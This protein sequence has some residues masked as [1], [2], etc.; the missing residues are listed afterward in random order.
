MPPCPLLQVLFSMARFR[1]HTLLIIGGLL[2]VHTAMF[3]LITTLIVT[4]ID[5]VTDLNS[6]FM[7]CRK[8]GGR[9]TAV[10]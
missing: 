4:Q 7:A 3:L 6:S 10:G 1:L 9:N 2:A 8:V 5:S